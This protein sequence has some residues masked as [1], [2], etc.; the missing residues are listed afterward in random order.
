MLHRR[1]W[2]GIGGFKSN[3]RTPVCWQQGGQ[4][5]KKKKER[6]NRKERGMQL[7]Q[8]FHLGKMKQD[9][10]QAPAS[11][12]GSNWTTFTSSRTRGTSKNKERGLRMIKATQVSKEDHFSLTFSQ[13][14]CDLKITGY[15]NL[16]QGQNDSH[17]FFPLLIVVTNFNWLD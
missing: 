2:D 16:V 8:T 10:H 17:F 5:K 12:W 9:L 1:E 3:L 6:K 11:S 15:T 4:T 7:S 14:D 13:G